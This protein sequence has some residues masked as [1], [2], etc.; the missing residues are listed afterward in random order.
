MKEI[1]QY[2]MIEAT[3]AVPKNQYW[4]RKR[5]P[6]AGKKQRTYKKPND[7]SF[8]IKDVKN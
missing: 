5:K 2:K 6:I 1:E 3:N 4:N 8:I 7:I